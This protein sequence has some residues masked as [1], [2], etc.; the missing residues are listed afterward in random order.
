MKRQK[1]QKSNDP[2]AVQ[3]GG[4]V[5]DQAARSAQHAAGGRRRPNPR[6]DG[7]EARQAVGRVQLARSHDVVRCSCARKNNPRTARR[8]RRRV[9]CV[10]GT[11]NARKTGKKTHITTRETRK[12]QTHGC[13]I[14]KTSNRAWSARWARVCMRQIVWGN[15]AETKKTTSGPAA[16]ARLRKKGREIA[17]N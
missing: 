5:A 1:V 4:R 6:L 3:G 9:V 7:G 17:K 10:G 2:E 14:V 8:R 15:A 12:K 11:R 13:V 16:V